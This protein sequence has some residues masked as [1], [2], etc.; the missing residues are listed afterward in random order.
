M[1]SGACVSVVE[2]KTLYKIPTNRKIKEIPDA[3]PA[4]EHHRLGDHSDQ[5]PTI[6]AVKI[7]FNCVNERGD[8]VN[9][10]D[11]MFDVIDGDLPILIGL[12]LLSE[13]MACVSFKHNNFG[14]NLGPRYVC[15]DLIKND[16]HLLLPFASTVQYSV[17]EN[18]GNSQ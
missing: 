14:M 10:F 3:T 8:P 16:N 17:S 11:I 12:P 18:A 9:S 13:M 5:Q 4:R 2:K 15:M 1:D 6:C 7:Q